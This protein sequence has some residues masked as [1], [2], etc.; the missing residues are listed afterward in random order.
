LWYSPGVGSVTLEKKG[1][2]KFGVVETEIGNM[3]VPIMKMSSFENV[4]GFFRNSEVEYPLGVTSL[5][6]FKSRYG[7]IFPNYES[8]KTIGDNL[9][10]NYRRPKDFNGKN[11]VYGFIRSD[12]DDL[13]FVYLVENNNIIDYEEMDKRY[14]EYIENSPGDYDVDDSVD[15]L[16]HE[17]KVPGDYD[18]EDSIDFLK[19]GEKGNDISP[20]D[21]S[22]NDFFKVGRVCVGDTCSTE[23][24]FDRQYRID[25][26]E[27]TSCM[28]D[29]KKEK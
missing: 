11:Q 3:R 18:V 20:D 22:D 4:Y 23:Y 12:I 15:F 8:L 5:D 25:D 19:Q 1:R 2:N 7:G 27:F 9:I 14:I 26:P 17:E 24:G 13:V 6:Q 21:K 28:E 10:L 29:D 16:K